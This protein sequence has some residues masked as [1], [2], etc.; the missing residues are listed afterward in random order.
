MLLLKPRMLDSLKRIVGSD[1][2]SQSSGCG[3]RRVADSMV[4]ADCVFA[5]GW[6]EEEALLSAIARSQTEVMMPDDEGKE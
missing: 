2:S 1:G 6:V 4:V 5:A 3:K